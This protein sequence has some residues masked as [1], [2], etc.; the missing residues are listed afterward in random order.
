M[1]L[2]RLSQMKSARRGFTLVELLVVIAIIGVLIGLL[3]PAVQQAREAARRM[4]CQ[5]NLKQ[6]G[7]ALH[8]YHDTYQSLSAGNQG[9]PKE[10]ANTYS[11]HGWTWHANILTFLEQG[12]LFDAIQGS[13]GFGNESGSQGAGKP[14]IV[15]DT[16]VSVFWCP[17][18]EDVTNGEA[19]NGY[20]PSNYNGNMG[21][22][23]GNGND[24]CECT[25]VSNLAEMR[26][27]A[28][29][30][31]NGNGI[32]YVDSKTRFADVRDGLS[33]TIFVSEVVDTGGQIMGHY[34]V[35]SDR[36]AIFSTG[37]DGNPPFEMTEYLIA[38]EGNDPIN[39]GAEEAAGSWHAGGANFVMGDGSVRFLSENMDMPTY[40]G[41]STRSEGEVLGGY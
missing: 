24:N 19:K 21:T 17:S 27:E 36:R 25:G 41:L 9:L 28:W 34:G 14:L 23:I 20:Q 15:R 1:K 32:F 12:N 22:R 10:S 26:S 40:Q 2:G 33:N 5:N 8:N 35:G 3:L 13:D 39:G 29:G 6:I 11:G 38:A 18:Q 7:L 37:A 30:C 31:M 16:V 4:H